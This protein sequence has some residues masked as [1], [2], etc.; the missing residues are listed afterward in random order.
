[1][2]EYVPLRYFRRSAGNMEILM[3]QG[4]RASHGTVAH[5]QRRMERIDHIAIALFGR[6]E[7]FPPL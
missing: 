7:V 4:A 6:S 5:W 2:T 1:M 3:L